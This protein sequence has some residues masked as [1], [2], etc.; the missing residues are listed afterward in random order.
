MRHLVIL[1]C[2]SCALFTAG[3]GGPAASC[4]L[5]SV[6]ADCYASCGQPAGGSVGPGD[7]SWPCQPDPLCESGHWKFDCRP[8]VLD[9]SCAGD[10]AGSPRQICG[11]PDASFSVALCECVGD[12]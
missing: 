10:L 3:C 6:N 1:A 7:A 4:T 9:M 5:D 12:P 11:V 8:A 2:V